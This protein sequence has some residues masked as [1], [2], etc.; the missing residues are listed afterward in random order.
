VHLFARSR[1]D[2]PAPD[3]QPL[4]FHVPAYLPGMEGPPDGFTLMAGMIRPQSRG[5]LTLASTDP[6][7]PPVIDP[8]YR[9]EEADLDAIAWSLEQVR[10]VGELPTAGSRSVR[11]ATGAVPPSGDARRGF[12]GDCECRRRRRP[13][14]PISPRGHFGSFRGRGGPPLPLPCPPLSSKAVS[15]PVIDSCGSRGMARPPIRSSV[16]D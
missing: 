5:R 12:Q 11:D 10:E 4:V 16:G 2:L 15:R 13:Q 1:S 3:T 8:A 6:D 9:A 7:A 14:I